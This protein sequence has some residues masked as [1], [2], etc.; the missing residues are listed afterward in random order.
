M[1]WL[2]APEGLCKEAF[3]PDDH[4]CV[5]RQ[6]V[7]VLAPAY[8]LA[9]IQDA[10]DEL[11]SRLYPDSATSPYEK[12]SWRTKG[13]TPKMLLAWCGA[14]GADCVI[15]HGR[16]FAASHRT[17]GAEKLVIASF[18]EAHAYLWKGAVARRV[19][20]RFGAAPKASPKQRL[21]E[22]TKVLGK[23]AARNAT[24]AFA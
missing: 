11:Q 3:A 17:Q 21:N 1:D 12:S 18:F 15:L 16:Q 8:E 20:K 4:M 6:L 14:H 24:P 5:P 13:V 22:A 19:A 2:P 7:E 9:E 10:F 23:Y